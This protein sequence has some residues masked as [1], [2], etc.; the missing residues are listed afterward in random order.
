[1]ELKD[2]PTI[3]LLFAL[4]EDIQEYENSLLIMKQVCNQANHQFFKAK[5]RLMEDVKNPNCR[6][7]TIRCLDDGIVYVNEICEKHNITLEPT[8]SVDS[9]SS[10]STPICLI[11][12]P[13]NENKDWAYVDAFRKHYGDKIDW[14]A[15]FN[16]G[17]EIGLFNTYSNFKSTKSC[18]FRAK[19][20][21]K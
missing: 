5:K 12:A 1:M 18:Y 2:D 6:K 9:S 19:S 21:R 15:C 14:E 16:I 17:K 8:D 3:Q 20:N 10:S 11:H 4:A 13:K 7:R